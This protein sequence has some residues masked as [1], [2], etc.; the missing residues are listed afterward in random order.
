MSRLPRPPYAPGT[1]L[2]RW[3]QDRL[4]LPALVH[5]TLTLPIPRNLNWM[6]IWGMVLLFCLVMQ[7]VTG[8][9]LAMH[10]TP[11][12]DH[13]FDS[14][15][16][17]MRDVN[18]GHFLRYLHANGASLFFVAIYFHIARGIYYGSHKS[19]RELTWIIGM[20]LYLLLMA[21]AFMGYVLP[22][23]QMSFWG[24]TVITG[25]FGAIPWVGESLQA[26]VLGGPAVGNPTLVRFFVLHWLLPFVA[27]ALVLLH[28]W[29]F[30]TTGNNNPTGVDPRLDEEG[31][32]RDMLPFWPYFVLKDLLALAVV[33]TAFF[34]LTAFAPNALG[35]PENYVPA[36]PLV[37]PAHIVPEWYFT[38]FYA[39]LR[40]FTSDLWLVQVAEVATFGLVDARLFGALALFG[41]LAVL[42]ALPWLDHSPVR[43]GRYR[44]AF[45][46][47]F[48][49][50]VLDFALLT[51][52][53]SQMPTARVAT[54]SLL[55]TAYWFGFFL[56]VL[57]LLSRRE[58]TR[59]L[60]PTIEAAS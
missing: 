40:A 38:P 3:M 23:G 35:H 27:V 20:M 14:V 5:A 16:R 41:S 22:W 17:I 24:A 45:R 25:L 44:P 21:V 2:G 39:I 36:N 33:L 15:E 18:G 9:V 28:I 56:I 42:L 4:P 47:A 26:W 8:V 30:H 54:L 11:H 43:S 1:A 49:V 32:R 13:A 57:P 50:L 59:P 31:M 29:S 10:Y 53:G 51:W 46:V 37:T 7:I 34:A 12:V 6:W 58:R 55:G 19:P 48:A 60:P 52:C